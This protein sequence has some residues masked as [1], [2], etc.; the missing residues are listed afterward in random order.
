MRRVAPFALGLV[1]TARAAGPRAGA[2]SQAVDGP[3][4]FVEVPGALGDDQSPPIEKTKRVQAFATDADCESYRSSIMR[5]A[6]VTGS[7]AMLE[8]ASSLRC[9][10]N[11]AG[12][13]KSPAK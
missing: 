6:A 9:L 12:A 2:S 11:T 3:W 5:D 13:A 8:E 1:L 10:R 4:L 7:D